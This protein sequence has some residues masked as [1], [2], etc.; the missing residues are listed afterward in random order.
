M[1]Q[2]A[3]FCANCGA[4]LASRSIAGCCPRCLGLAA[5]GRP[6]DASV[7]GAGESPRARF[8]GGYE[9][10]GEIGRGGMGVVYRARQAGLGREVA[11]KVL[12]A[13]PYAD[14]VD[15]ASF[16]AEAASAAALRHPGIVTVFEVGE[17][18]GHPYFSMELVQGTTLASL[19]AGG[20]LEARRAAR[21]VR[22]VAEAVGAAHARGI[23]HRD[24]KPGNVLIDL[25]D[26]ARVTDF[27]LAR[28]LGSEST[29]HI[30]GS[31]GYMPPEQA[32]PL[33]GGIGVASDVY[34]LG[35]LL[36]H[37]LT[38]RPPFK[39]S[40]VTATLAQVLT[41]E[42]VRPRQINSRLPQ[43]LETICLKCL[44]KEPLRRY[45]SALEVAEELEAFLARRPIKA[46]RIGATQRAWLWARR[47]PGLATM[48]G[49]LAVVLAFGSAAFLWQSRENHFNLYAAD[50]RIAAEDIEHG[51]LTR[52]RT[53]LARHSPILGTAPFT[54]RYLKERSE[55]DPRFLLGQ[56]PW[57]VTSI[58]WSPDGRWIASGSL[59]SGTVGA[60][61]RIWRPGIS[62][63]P[64]ILTTNHIREIQWFPDSWR[65]LAVGASLGAA[66]W[67]VSD[68]RELTNYPASTAQISKDGR[69][70]VTCEGDPVVWNADGPARAVWLR[71]LISGQARRFPDAR[72]AALS[73]SGRKIAL[74]DITETIDIF[75]VDSGTREQRLTGTGKVWAIVFSDDDQSLVVTGFDPDVRVW[76]LSAAQ[77][78]MERWP[79]HLLP[80]WQAAFSPDGTRLLSTSSDQT[81]HLW[82]ARTGTPLDIYR[83]HGS[84]VWCA[85]FSP[86]GH[87][88]ATGG[89]DRNVFVW[90]VAKP[91]S[92]TIIKARDWGRRFFSVDSQR[93]VAISAD[94]PPRALAH[95]LK[96]GTPSLA[97]DTIDALALD[98]AGNLLLRR[99]PFTLEWID[100]LH[101]H[102]A[103]EVILE[104]DLN[105]QPP[106]VW[107]ISPDGSLLAGLSPEKRLSSWDGHTGRRLASLPVRV[108]EAW[109][110]ALS[111][112]GNWAALTLG[113]D[114]FLLCSLP[115]QT[116]QRLTAH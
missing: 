62:A 56:H 40:T 89:K 105:E 67:D 25:A 112:D 36:Y 22:S 59:G 31:P 65:L 39:D 107:D 34:G 38:A 42:P 60:D 16:R 28:E 103:R 49:L 47:H 20:P 93:L 99:A 48:S 92:Q 32:D 19:T 90:P 13:G 76:R 43:D 111:P 58:A 70:L 51:D 21:Y 17:A 102:A 83:G 37:L 27:G 108:G 77:P 7:S 45:A 82:E 98:A 61:L 68:G 74:S 4:T 2:S 53:L 106:R 72:L 113:E 52:A 85:A 104:H 81:V 109:A 57:I 11:L 33:R 63:P 84:E 41:K 79:G 26:E 8:L 97:F 50:L 29:Q 5:F 30:A 114:G 100:I 91:S 78:A 3:E 96:Q 18:D 66:I 64:V 15:V 75:D 54:W 9:L 71:E 116:S 95:D 1:S 110:L 115:G 35:A 6:T 46:R 10:L 12:A 24:L 87:Q 23:L 14:A 55:G 94:D 101:H 73:P 88:F 80:T 86:D 44:A 69:R